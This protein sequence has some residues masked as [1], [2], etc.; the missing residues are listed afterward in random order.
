MG[1]VFGTSAEE[2]L[3]QKLVEDGLAEFQP[4][5]IE[6]PEESAGLG[7]TKTEFG[8]IKQF[9]WTTG[10]IG[11]ITIEKVQDASMTRNANAHLTINELT[12]KFYAYATS[13]CEMHFKKAN[14]LHFSHVHG[15]KIVVEECN[16][17][18]LQQSVGDSEFTV[19]KGKVIC[20]E[21]ADIIVNKTKD[22]QFFS[23]APESE[24][25]PILSGEEA[26][27]RFKETRNV[28]PGVLNEI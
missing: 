11:K 14:I 8:T 22:V 26:I 21:S 3:S 19:K 4:E 1:G 17:C 25:K 16:L 12:G 24:Q 27:A 15:C 10:G 6:G 28:K 2:T 23:A 5:A 13:S 7:E 18:V 20:V 9:D